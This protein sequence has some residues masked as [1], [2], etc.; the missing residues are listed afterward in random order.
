MDVLKAIVPAA[1]LGTRFLPYTK[2]VPKELLPLLDKPALHYIAEE[3]AA[4]GVKDLLLITGQQKWAISNYFDSDRLAEAELL[5]AGSKV[6][7]LAG[8]KRLVAQ[9]QFS[10]VQQATP[11]GLGDAVWTARN[12]IGK[13]YFGV[14]LPDDIIV[15]P[16]P[17]LLQLLK[18]AR[19]EKASV[20]AVQEVP[21]ELLGQY[22]VIEVRK[23]LT[24][25]LFQ[26]GNLIEKPE[27]KQAPSNLAIIGR[28]ILTPKLFPILDEL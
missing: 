12:L 23:Q 22:G 9:L 25:S 26:V 21:R 7:P 24:P 11:R 16:T 15:S 27:P 19:Q 10:Y 2:A 8:L 17:G 1:G 14:L 6:S 28:Y 18:I 13:E 3:A 5:Y 20:L 4:A